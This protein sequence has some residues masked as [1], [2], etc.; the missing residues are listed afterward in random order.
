MAVPVL[1]DSAAEQSHLCELLHV[2]AA[3]RGK[4]AM[5]LSPN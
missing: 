2:L 1:G 4:C 5:A 3:G